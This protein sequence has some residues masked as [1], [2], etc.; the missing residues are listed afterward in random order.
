MRSP[1]Q[2]WRL[3]PVVAFVDCED[4][5]LRPVSAL[6]ADVCMPIQFGCQSTKLFPI[7]FVG[8]LPLALEGCWWVDE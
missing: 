7:V 4:T 8:S 5:V 2:R 1:Q 3:R 6:L